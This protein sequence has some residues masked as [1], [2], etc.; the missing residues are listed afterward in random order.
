[1]QIQ[2]LRPET[3]GE[4]L[5]RRME[6]RISLLFEVELWITGISIAVETRHW[7]GLSSLLICFYGTLGILAWRLAKAMSFGL[8]VL[9]ALTIAIA[10]TAFMVP[11]IQ[12]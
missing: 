10:F 5:P 4:A 9:M 2:S 7:F 11:L 3:G 1:M 12:C 6:P 8:A